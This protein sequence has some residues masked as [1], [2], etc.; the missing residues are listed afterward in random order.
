MGG[1]AIVK[2]KHKIFAEMNTEDEDVGITLEGLG[3]SGGGGMAEG[4]LKLKTR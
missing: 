2:K 4:N 1:Q 3:G